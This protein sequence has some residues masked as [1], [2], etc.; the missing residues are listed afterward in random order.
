M[1]LKY[2]TI[3]FLVIWAQLLYSQQEL[4]IVNN[5]EFDKG[6]IGWSVKAYNNAQMT[7]EVKTDGLLSGANYLSINISTGGNVED[8]AVYQNQSLEQGRFYSISFIASA[9]RDFIMHAA[10]IETLGDK[11]TFWSSPDIQL[12]Q[13]A[14]TFG[15]FNVAYYGPDAGHRLYFFLGGT[16]NVTVNIDAVV[17]TEKDDPNHFRI[18]E[19]FAQRSHT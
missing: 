17:I 5:P 13:V 15:P 19:K 12:T 10:L 14:H 2:M 6:K 18:E 8:I 11:K 7:F 16:D 4:N 9:N 3:W 1:K